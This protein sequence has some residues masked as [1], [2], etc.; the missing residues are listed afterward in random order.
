MNDYPQAVHDLVDHATASEDPSKIGIALLLAQ[1]Q[2][3]RG[4]P[5]A[6]EALI[7]AHPHAEWAADWIEARI[8]PPHTPKP[9]TSAEA[10]AVACMTL[11]DA[12]LFG[13]PV[14]VEI[15]QREVNKA[16][17]KNRTRKKW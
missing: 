10:Y 3:G 12:R 15:A 16:A 14:D 13:R 8:A 5:E 4:K 2:A 9:L 17:A 1:L 11:E 7:Y 6:V